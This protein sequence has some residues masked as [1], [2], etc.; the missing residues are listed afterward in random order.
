MERLPVLVL[1]S[2]G[3]AQIA[4]EI[5]GSPISGVNFGFIDP[6]QGT[7][8]PQ[9]AALEETD[10]LATTPAP[11]PSGLLRFCRCLM[12]GVL[13]RSAGVGSGVVFKSNFYPNCPGVFIQPSW[14]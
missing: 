8:Q 14:D 10:L 12:M 4:S 2:C 11:K 6:G 9:G 13:P 3:S 5:W 1:I 7:K